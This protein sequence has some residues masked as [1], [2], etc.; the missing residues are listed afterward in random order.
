MN[1][2][3]WNAVPDCTASVDTK[4][5]RYPVNICKVSVLKHVLKVI[6]VLASIKIHTINPTTALMSVLYLHTIFRNFMF[7][8]ILIIFREILNFNEAF[9]KT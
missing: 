8:S 2:A 5:V 6:F 9:I 1:T 3:I 7:R 4:D